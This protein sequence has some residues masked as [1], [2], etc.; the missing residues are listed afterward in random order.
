MNCQSCQKE[1]DK[2]LERKLSDD[3]RIQVELH[4]K[5]CNECAESYR[6]LSTAESI[7]NHEKTIEPEKDLTARIMGRIGILEATDNIITNPFLRVLQPALIITSIAATIFPRG[8][9][10]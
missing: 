9:D 2:Y 7:I 10:R 8:I 1:S 6:I 4:L 5:Q 3:L